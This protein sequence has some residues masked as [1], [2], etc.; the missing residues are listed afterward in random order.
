[1]D[2]TKSM[3]YVIHDDESVR[4][5]FGRLVRP[6]ENDDADIRQ[7]VREPGNA[8]FFRKPVDDQ[9][10]LDAISWAVSGPGKGN[11]MHH[12]QLSVLA[13]NRQILGKK[14]K[15]AVQERMGVNHTISVSCRMA[16]VA[17]MAVA[18][19]DNAAGLTESMKAGE[20]IFEEAD[21]ER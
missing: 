20:S 8:A 18:C 11:K 10:L 13:G 3:I 7:R 15:M 6:A 14:R 21:Y 9:T 2:R 5:A 12:R 16:A 19:L 4:S 1:M 17:S